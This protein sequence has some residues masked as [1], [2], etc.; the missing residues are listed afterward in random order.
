M[1][2]KPGSD[3]PHS[4]DRIVSFGRRFKISMEYER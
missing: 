2:L 4:R 3:L 1:E